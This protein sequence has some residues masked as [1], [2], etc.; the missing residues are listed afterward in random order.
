MLTILHGDALSQL[1]KIESESVQ[2]VCTS[3]PYFGLRDYGVEGQLGLERTPEEYVARLVEIFREVRRVLRADG[4]AWLNLGDSY[5]GS[6]RGTNGDGSADILNSAK[7]RSNTGANLDMHDKRVEA[8]AIGRYWVAPPPGM[9]PKDLIG[10]PWSVAEALRGPYYTGRIKAERDRAWMAAM[11]DG[12]GSICGFEHERK[13]GGGIRTGINLCITNSNTALLDEAQRIFPASRAEHCTP[14]DGHLGLVPT[15]RWLVNGAENKALFLREIYPYLIAKRQQAIIGYTMACLMMDAKRLGKTDQAQA[16]REKRS[17]LMRLLSQTNHAQ[18]V[19]IPS[20]CTEPPDCYEPGWYLRSDI[21]WSKPNPMPESVADRP[22]KAHEYIFLLSKS[23]RY[24]FDQDAVKE[25]Q[26]PC[27]ADRTKYTFD[28]AR[29]RL[30]QA[31]INGKDTMRGDQLVPADGLRNIRSVWHVAT[32]PYP[33]AHFATYPPALITP[34][35]LAGSKAGDVVLDPFAGS[36]TTGKV[37]IELGRRAILI[38]PKA[39]YVAMIERRC[40]TTIG[41]PI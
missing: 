10:I 22:T 27:S 19:D 4:T 33:D 23:A 5:A 40:K 13:D 8:G 24:Y 3:P 16:V 1:P 38:E 31:R 20:W 36:G 18:T 11:I 9:K 29:A 35:I 37:A 25:Q 2:M 28:G 21:I 34:C 30:G 26:Q 39:E 17:L 41:L 15:W 6:G 32:Q 14:G 12:E 7:Q